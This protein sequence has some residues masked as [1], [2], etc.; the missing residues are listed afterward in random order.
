MVRTA[1]FIL[2]LLVA[3]AGSAVEGSDEEWIPLFNGRDLDGWT[4]KFQGHPAGENPGHVFRVEDGLL[5]VSYDDVPQFENQF[6][7]LFYKTPFSHYRLRA[8]YRFVGEQAAGGPAWA[9]RNNGLML[10][11]PPPEAMALDQSFPDSIEV[12]LLGGNGTDERSTGNVCTP[13]TR[14]VLNGE[15]AKEHCYPSTSETYHGDQWVTIEVEVHGHGEIVHRVNGKEVL[16]YEQ[17]QLDDGTPLDSGT[18]SIQAESHP[19]DFRTIE[20]LPLDP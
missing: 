12:Q 19:T 16:R 8:E 18:I 13:G 6:G 10:H 4:P 11:G 7:H 14:I 17:P 1:A 2:T 20:I 15:L 9:F 5:R 3:V